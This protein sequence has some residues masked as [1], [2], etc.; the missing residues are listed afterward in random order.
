[1]SHSR[2]SVTAWAVLGF[3]V[4]VILWGALVRATGSGAGCG[5]H[6]PQCN[7]EI[8]PLG[9][10]TDTTIE[11]IHRMTSAIALA[12]VVVVA[13]WAFK[14]FGRGHRVTTAALTAVVV[15]FV[16]AGIGAVLV[17]FGWTGDDAS[18]GR[19]ITIPI[20]LVNTFVLLGALSVTAF[21]STGMA[22][23]DLRARPRTTRTFAVVLGLL[24]IVGA[25]GA[26]TALGDTLFPPESLVDGLRQDL[27]FRGS[28]LVRLRVVHPIVAIVAGVVVMIVARKA[29]MDEAEGFDALVALSAIGLVALQ[30]IVG[31]VNVALLAPTAIQIVHLL[32]ADSLWI[33]T[34][35]LA[36]TMLRGDRSQPEPID[37][38]KAIAA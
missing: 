3:N 38:A 11:F 35:L 7:G 15:I 6:W 28:V 14:R 31:F 8:V 21:W 18:L 23:V 27:S 24:L 36:A 16:E 33:V 37:A 29:L 13:I 4:L 2:F 20:H 30:I 1:M 34:V 32:L 5:N 25:A 10:T 22:G 17:L 26:L 9:A 12:A 19:I